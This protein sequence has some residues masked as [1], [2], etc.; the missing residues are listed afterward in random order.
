VRVSSPAA[1]AQP[2][3]RWQQFLERIVRLSEVESVEID[4]HHGT[5]AIAFDRQGT[6]L[7]D[8]LE[9]MA[10]ALAQPTAGTADPEFLKLSRSLANRSRFRVYRRGDRL[11]VW[12]IVHDAPG[13]LRVRD[14]DLEANPRA[15]LRVR[16]EL[17]NLDGIHDVTVGSFTGSIVI[18][19]DQAAIDR[20]QILAHLDRLTGEGEIS[21]VSQVPSRA[22]WMFANATL[23][24]GVAG[25]VVY[26]PLLPVSAVLLVA[27]NIPTFHNAWRELRR[28]HVGLPLLHTTIVGATLATGGFVASSLMNWL[29]TYWEDRHARL[30]A[31]G[32]QLLA[33]SVRKPRRTAWVV[34]DGVELE[35]PVSALQLKDVISVRAGEVVP[36]DGRIL[37]GTG[38]VNENSLGGT[39]GLVCRNVGDDL[40][41][42]AY[43]A[44]GELQIEV[45]RSG[46]ATVA[47]SIGRTLE[48]SAAGGPA[49]GPAVPSEF[50]ERAVPPALA[51]ASLGFLV[52]DATMAAAVLRPDYATGPG[53]GGSVT[54]IERLG[55]CFDEGIVVRRPDVFHQMAQAD[56]V[57]LDHA[58]SLS[59]RI[60]ELEDVH[61]AGELSPDAV[62]EYAECAVRQFHDPRARAVAVA[63]AFQGGVPLQF[64]VRF[65][66][67]GVEFN[68]GARRV[69]VDGLSAV[70]D[71]DVPAEVRDRGAPL[72]VHVDGDLAGWLTFYEGSAC[73]AAS[74]VFDL[75]TRCGM[76]VELLAADGDAAVLAEALGVDDVHICPS[77]AAKAQMIRTLR[78]QGRRVVYVGN[79]RQNPE[80][81]AIANVAVFP[82]PDLTWAADPAGVWLLQPYYEKLVQLRE[83][84]RS[85]RRQE[86]LDFNLILIPNVVCVAGAFLF[87]LTSLAVVV[88][89]NLGTF[90]VYSRS[91][92]ALQRTQRRLRERHKRV[93]QQVRNGRLD[94]TSRQLILREN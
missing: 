20:R 4:R 66:S 37:A 63:F 57:L 89:S 16:S 38:L 9:R 33:D 58:P 10:A 39:N 75:R 8:L 79:C 74:P 48:A 42:G 30:K 82:A 80:S 31:A 87:G 45:L 21:A 71:A 85:V 81:A 93:H 13:R 91:R 90:S 61:V 92:A 18:R 22:R 2:G 83:V 41:E 73:A 23:A 40:L 68:D 36:V 26:P 32:H 78:R 50:A 46:D 76:Q 69:R 19:Y 14:V 6:R 24:L 77:D 86:Q 28:R 49:N 3:G 5:A 7:D 15:A 25:A 56:V 65:R 1:L 47:T 34:R 51:T 27:S 55:A 11:S 72:R 29:L 64:P 62:L 94:E 35:T 43:L 70:R 52:G 67:G 12:E 60:L 88:L 53:I 84:A 59:A 54:L 44:E 17:E